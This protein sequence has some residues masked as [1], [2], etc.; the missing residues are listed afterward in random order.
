MEQS[1][2]LESDSI[3]AGQEIP[4][5]LLNPTVHYGVHNSPPLFSILSQFQSSL[6]PHTLHL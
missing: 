4:R 2:Y 1:Y 6:N 5:L 3:S